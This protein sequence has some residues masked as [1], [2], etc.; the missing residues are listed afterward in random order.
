MQLSGLNFDK[1]EES[2]RERTHH[3]PD[4]II[5]GKPKWA[6]VRVV[7][8]K[9]GYETD[10]EFSIDRLN[11]SRHMIGKILYMTEYAYDYRMSQRISPCHA[12]CL[13]FQIF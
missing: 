9:G 7:R 13:K 3:P 2:K 12:C 11:P 8:R 6:E 4:Q 10:M 1:M 5:H